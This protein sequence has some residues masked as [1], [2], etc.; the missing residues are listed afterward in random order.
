[1]DALEDLPDNH[2]LSHLEAALKYVEDWGCA[3]D[4]GA[5]RGIWTRVLA[6][7]FEEVYAFEPKWSNF[8]KLRG[9]P[10]HV[11]RLGCALGEFES[12]S[13]IEAGPENT[14]QYYLK[15]NCTIGCTHVVALDKFRLKPGFIKLDVE[16]YELFALRGAELTIEK[17]HPVILIEENGLCERY[18]VKRMEADEWLKDHGYKMVKRMNKDY[19]YKYGE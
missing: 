12:W 15:P 17:H 6:V 8:T 11:H 16:G 10:Q 14:G 18:G 4:G 2:D 1:M 9:L 5:H 3:V 13:S 7:R 19:I